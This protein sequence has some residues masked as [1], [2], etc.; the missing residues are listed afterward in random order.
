MSRRARGEGG[1]HW[2][3]KRRRWIATLTVGYSPKGKRLTRKA[4][5]KTE[6]GAAEKLK[7][8]RADYEDGLSSSQ[9]YTVEDAVRNWLQYGLSGR[10]PKTVEKNTIL[11]EQHII[12]DLGAR[13]LHAPLDKRHELAADDVDRWLADKAKTHSTR[14][15]QEIR[16]I[17]KRSIAR[18]QARDKAKRNVVELCEV[19]Q[20]KTGRP[21]KA[22]TLGQAE[23]V[24]KAA[25]NDNST[26]GAY[27]VVSLLTGARTEEM[28][29]LR[30]PEVDLEGNPA[31]VA[32]VPIPPHMMVWRSV[33]AGGDTKTKKS[34]RT[35]A[36]PARCVKAL[37]AQQERQTKTRDVAGTAW[38]NLGLVFASDVGTELDAANVRRAFRRI[39]KAAGINPQEWTPRELRHS[40]VSLL[41]DNGVPLESIARLC[42]HSGTAVTELVYRHQIRPVIDEGATVMD[43]I[44]PQVDG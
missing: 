3:E 22:L 40:F 36:L 21:S 8:L 42:G 1:I 24:L 11:A 7:Q 15:L 41:S 14:T 27:V 31:G 2:D 5:A 32:G 10:S 28:R 20:G 13:K 17:L 26:I 34:R 33:R 29:P 12:P 9:S 43:H 35:I 25:E 16:S 18:A 37:R 30:W 38:Q 19:P 39:V 44:F 23:A 4:S 6:T